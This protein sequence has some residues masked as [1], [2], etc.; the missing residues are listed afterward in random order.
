MRIAT[1][2]GLFIFAILFYLGLAIIVDGYFDGNIFPNDATPDSWA[3]PNSWSNWRDIF[4]VFTAFFWALS[5]LLLCILLGALVYL[6]LFTRSLMRDKVSPVLD[7]A[8]ESLDRI[9]GTVEYT[10]E[11]VVSP[12]IRTYA[13]FKGVRTGLGA[14][15]NLPDRIRG[16]KKGGKR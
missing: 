16:R 14:V 13:V 1:I 4:I 3:A 7:S 11:T 8:K 6:A 5:G 9:Q 2:A 12:I 15:T 10:G